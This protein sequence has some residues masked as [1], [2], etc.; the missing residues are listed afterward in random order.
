ML[1]E[2]SLTIKEWTEI[3]KSGVKARLKFLVDDGL[4]I[5]EKQP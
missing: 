1:L 5:C 3:S 2:S 4:Y